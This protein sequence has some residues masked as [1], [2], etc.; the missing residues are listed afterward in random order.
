MMAGNLVKVDEQLHKTSGR[1][2]LLAKLYTVVL[3]LL[4][5]TMGIGL[6]AWRDE[7]YQKRLRKAMYTLCIFS[8]SSFNGAW[9]MGRFRI[10]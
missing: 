4:E 2:T 7:T 8:S 5:W 1:R 9:Q 10:M 6:L 3:A